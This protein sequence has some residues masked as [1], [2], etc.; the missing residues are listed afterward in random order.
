MHPCIAEYETGKEERIMKKSKEAV[1]GFL[2]G[3]TLTAL[4]V[5]APSTLAAAR[6]KSVDV[7][8]NDIKLVVDGK[9]VT[10][11]DVNGN[12]VEPFILDGT[13]YLPV[14]AAVNAITGGTKQVEWEQ[15]TATIYIGG[16][17]DQAV[18][19]LAAL[20]AFSGD[21]GFGASPASF[22]CRQQT[23]TPFNRFGGTASPEKT[24][25]TYLLNGDYETF[26]ASVAAI[27][28]QGDNNVSIYNA[29]TNELLKEVTAK[30]GEAPTDFT[31]DVAGVDKL[32]IKVSTKYNNYQ[33]VV[34]YTPTGAL[35]NA[36]LTRVRQG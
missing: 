21:M 7:V 14:R 28:G 2:A 34:Y 31:V 8:Y 11:T 6:K 1:Q 20:K 32:Q 12:V 13:T 27:D 10:P 5:T 36:T 17:Q 29:D 19:D 35:Y 26:S 9:A 4:V 18:V 16:R 22:Q 23:Y 15:S 24:Y 3:V 25:A 33:T 30:Q